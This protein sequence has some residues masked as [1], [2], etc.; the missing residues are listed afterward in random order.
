MQKIHTNIIVYEDGS[1]KYQVLEE[2]T[3]GKFTVPS[4]F[5]SDG[6]SVPRVFWSL[7]PPVGKY[8]KSCILH[9]W[10]LTSTDIEWDQA[11]NI[12]YSSMIKD[13]V[14]KPKAY[15]MYIAVKYWGIMPKFINER[16]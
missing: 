10:L 6:A 2:I 14:G 9:D 16:K 4:G 13:G 15:I 8:F 1:I 5:I 11:A 3:F 12:F 7:F